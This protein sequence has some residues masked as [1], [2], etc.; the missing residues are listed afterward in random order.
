MAIYR[1]VG[2]AG[3]ISSG[4]TLN[5]VTELTLR[6]EDA[7]VEA[8]ASATA[9]AS[10][11]AGVTAITTEIV[12]VA[13]IAANVTSVAGISTNVTTVA[14]ISTDVS[15]VAGISSAVTAVNSNATNI[16]AVAADAA[17][18]AIVGGISADV[19]AVA[20]IDS[21]V[22]AVAADATDIG[23]VSADLAGSNTIGTVAAI[24]PNVTTVAGISTNVTTV[25]S[26]TTNV[27]TVATNIT[28]VNT[29]GGIS[30]DVTTVAGISADVAA[31]ENIA[32]NVTTVAG[33]A[34]NVT[35]VAGISSAVTGVNTI[36]SA[37]SAVD[38]NATNINTVAGMN[39]NVTT[40][41]GNATN[42]NTV[43]GISGNVTTVAGI[44][45]DVT[46]VATN[47]TDVSN[48]ANV[49]YGSAA[50]NPTERPNATASQEGDLYFNT[51][52]D[53]MRVFT[54][55]G[56]GW[57]AAGSAVNGTSER[58]VYT[59]TASQTTFAVVYDAGYVDVYQ[60][61]VKL[62]AGTDFTSTSGTNIVL[63]TGA[64]AGDII[65]IVAYGA[66]S[67]ADVY[68]KSVSDARFATAAQ[69]A[70]AA[71]ALQSSDIGSTVQ[72]Y[73]ATIVVDADIGVTVQGY[74]ATIV[75]DAD[76]GSTVQAYDVD[77]TKNDVA[78]TFTATQTFGTSVVETKV[79]MGAHDIDLS[80]GNYFTYT[81]SGAQTLTV[82]N[83][84][85]SGSV[86]AFVLEVTNGGSAA[87]TFFSGVTWAAATAPTLTAAGV[88]TLAFFTSDGGTTWR[89]FVLG[90][91]MA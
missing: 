30:G 40:V 34:P 51:T 3:D 66:F 2:G 74:D 52:A 83:V 16:N 65:D 18:I 22:S 61:G 44:S 38:T 59:A 91:G 29:V 85:S 15:S 26:N 89:G 49:Y 24:A 45:T 37:V 19:T 60:N 78:N 33:I 82:S 46:T 25:A 64:N 68:T 75:V 9:A 81:L 67:L 4:I 70:L 56:T 20:A 17:N 7:A 42:I 63:A 86:S 21:A 62:V 55:V 88:D 13:G 8:E 41:A 48:F 27:N 90:L 76:I 12:T 58:V 79:A 54:G 6:A 14:G 28:N 47:V 1:G 39:A 10:S 87:L 53:Q 43:A 31:V 23:V 5:E 73:D 72:A 80:A 69:G 11:V 50:S 84:A 32:A 35:T 57:V 71:S 36:S 77:T